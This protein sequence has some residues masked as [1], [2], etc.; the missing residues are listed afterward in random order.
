MN[1]LKTYLLYRFYKKKKAALV[2]DV[3]VPFWDGVSKKDINFYSTLLSIDGVTTARCTFI[4]A[5]QYIGKRAI[6]AQFDIE[7]IND[8][9]PIRQCTFK[10]FKDYYSNFFT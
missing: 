9:K 10:E 8:F 6:N 3:T 5:K 7:Y 2:A 4:G 1:L